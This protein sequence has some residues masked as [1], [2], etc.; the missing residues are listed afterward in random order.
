M[1]HGSGGHP[2]ADGALVHR[3]DGEAEL[4]VVVIG[5][6]REV[7]RL[8]GLVQVGVG[9][10][11][12]ARH[13]LLASPLYDA[14]ACGGVKRHEAVSEEVGVAQVKEVLRHV[15]GLREEV[16]HAAVGLEL[17]AGRKDIGGDKHDCRRRKCQMSLHK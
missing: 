6:V 7:K 11:G 12:L 9:V 13:E 17:G 2:Y 10:E 8:Q 1:L 14:L 3:L 4:R 16:L 15:P 5:R